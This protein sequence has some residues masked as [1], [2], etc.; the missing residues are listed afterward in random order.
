M[1]PFVKTTAV[2]SEDPGQ[3]PAPKSGSPQPPVTA[4]PGY[5]PLPPASEGTA[6]TQV[7]HIH[8]TSNKIN[9]E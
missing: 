4:A 7:R 9:P 8:I 3:L 5:L 2:F 1:R 6:H